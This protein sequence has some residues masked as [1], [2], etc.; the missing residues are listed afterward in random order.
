[1][2][3]LLISLLILSI[4]I[5]FTRKE[6]YYG[7]LYNIDYPGNENMKDIAMYGNITSQGCMGMCDSYPNCVGFS[8]N[9]SNCW[10]KSSN[11]YFSANLRTSNG[12]NT[13]FK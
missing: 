8:Q 2:K 6:G 11:P 13:Y 5:L 3:Y 1:M 4:I 9:G 10:I 7:P 12:T